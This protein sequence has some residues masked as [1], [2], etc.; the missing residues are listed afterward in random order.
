MSV[1]GRHLK[2]TLGCSAF[3]GSCIL[4]HTLLRSESCL[5]SAR[6]AHPHKGAD[7]LRLHLFWAWLHLFCIVPATAPP[8]PSQQPCTK[9]ASPNI[10]PWCAIVLPLPS[11]LAHVSLGG[12]LQE[13]TQTRHMLN[14]VQQQLQ[15]SSS[16]ASQSEQQHE[17]AVGRLTQDLQIEQ[18]ARSHST[19]LSLLVHDAG[20]CATCAHALH[21]QMVMFASANGHAPCI[22][23]GT[24]WLRCCIAEPAAS[25]RSQVQTWRPV[26]IG[27]GSL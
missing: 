12:T 5:S 4:R 18:K 8:K 6:C 24:V 27:L 25:S 7:P 14:K 16:Q 1:A 21:P 17:Q 9:H 10:Q 23:K 20:H 3:V 15:E 22:V 11:T 2:D 26:M 19:P 13:L